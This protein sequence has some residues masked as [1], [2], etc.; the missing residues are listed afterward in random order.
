ML[1]LVSPHF[2]H[3]VTALLLA[4]SYWITSLSLFSLLCCDIALPHS[5]VSLPH[6]AL[7]YCTLSHPHCHTLSHCFTTL[8]WLHHVA[9]L[10][11]AVFH[12]TSSLAVHRCTFSLAVHC[13]TLLCIAAGV[14]QQNIF[15]CR[16]NIGPIMDGS[17]GG[18]ITINNNTVTAT[19][20]TKTATSYRRGQKCNNQ[21]AAISALTIN[22]QWEKQ[23]LCIYCAVANTA[24]VTAV[25]IKPMCCPAVDCCRE[26]CCW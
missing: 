7:G 5:L 10:T 18:G 9:T 8:C 14:Q 13:R 22:W 1:S 24:T 12:H 21:S 15:Y 3:H 20:M 6:I 11:R 4:F 26:L 17:S 16:I 19:V 23:Q 25:A 2:S